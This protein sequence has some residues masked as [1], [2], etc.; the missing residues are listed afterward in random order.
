[1]VWE[2]A[3]NTLEL[4][5]DQHGPAFIASWDQ[6]VQAMR[7]EVCRLSAACDGEYP[8]D[9]VGKAGKRIGVAGAASRVEFADRQ[10]SHPWISRRQR[11]GLFGLAEGGPGIAAA[12][13]FRQRGI[14]KVQ[15][16]DVD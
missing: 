10:R 9:A 1:P 5:C 7:T 8:G 4:L 14:G 15:D 11:E 16:I 13:I 3:R 2:N 12:G 6:M